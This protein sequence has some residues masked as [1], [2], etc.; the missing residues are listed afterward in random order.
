MYNQF[1]TRGIEP[2]ERLD[3]WNDVMAQTYRGLS[4]SPLQPGFSAQ[5]TR[6]KL[7][8]TIL[9]RP[10]STAVSVERRHE[11]VSRPTSRTL[12]LHFLHKG[13]GRLHHRRR[14]IDLRQGDL[15]ACAG[16]ENYRFEMLG[17]H[18]LLIAELD[19]ATLRGPV[20][21]IDDIIGSPI[22]R[23]T[24]GVRLLY[25]FLLSLWRES[26]TLEDDIA[27]ADLDTVLANMVLAGL[28]PSAEARCSQQAPLWQRAKAII[29]SRL[30]DSQLT[31]A[32]LAGELGVGLR[33]LQAAAAEASTTPGS[34]ITAGCRQAPLHHPNR[35]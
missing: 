17:P 24:A 23:E 29:A 13:A 11:S 31:P 10:V 25:D 32:A 34:Y 7:G 20:D 30:G 33:S 4:A 18:E 12:K 2:A 3:A 8:S 1:S 15:I 16:E 14:E 22:P 5:I 6:W 27:C 26:D 9:T 19:F 28:R 21:W 35:L